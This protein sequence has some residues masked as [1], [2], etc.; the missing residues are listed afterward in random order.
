MLDKIKLIQK[1]IEIKK[2]ILC[3]KY[4]RHSLKKN[5][6]EYHKKEKLI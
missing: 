1:K 5:D 4:K 6:K 3:W 2:K